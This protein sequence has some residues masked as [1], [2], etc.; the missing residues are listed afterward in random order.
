M[1]T[2]TNRLVLAGLL[3]GLCGCND[4]EIQTE[5]DKDEFR[6]GSA[7][8]LWVTYKKNPI[9]AGEATARWSSSKNGAIGEGTDITLSDLKAG[10]HDLVVEVTRDGK[11]AK[12]KRRIEITNDS[13]AATIQ[14]PLQGTKLGVG[15]PLALRGSAT[16]PEDG[17]LTG[18]S[19][20]WSS[21]LDGDLGAGPALELTHLRP[22]T[23][24]ISMVA[25]DRAGAESRARV[26][27][28][29]TNEAPEV[30]ISQPSG[31]VTI[32]VTDQLRLRGF[33]LDRDHRLG[34]ERVAGSSLE[35][36]SSKDGKLGVGEELTV[37][38]LSGGTHVVELL[39]KDEFGKVGRASLK[40]KVENQPPRVKIRRPYPNKFFSAS[41]AVRFEVEAED[42]EAALDP[43]DI[44][45]RSNKDGVIGRGYDFSSDRLSEGKHEVTCT[46]TD[47]H[48]ASA[49]DEVTLQINNEAPTA[50]IV[51]PS[52]GVT[53]R[54]GETL[55]VEGQGTDPEDGTLDDDRLEWSVVKLETGKSRRLGTGRRRTDSVSS[56]ANEVGFGRLELRLVATDRDGKASPVVALALTV[57]NRA[58]VVHLANPLSGATVAQ[59]VKLLCSGYGNDPD[60]GRLLEGAELQWSARRVSDGIMRELGKGTR[61][62]VADLLP[63][64]WEIT[65]TGIDPDDQALRH[66]AKVQVT[67][68]EAPAAPPT[69]SVTPDS[70]PAPVGPDT[71]GINTVVGQ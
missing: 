52:A 56:F 43:N 54:F 30:T 15:K 51:S 50:R 39:A 29:V 4:L 6:F 35:W 21:S 55:S 28:E 68:T 33:A 19:L 11:S 22:G 62:E 31:D 34:P 49:K 48:G 7:V 26:S 27:I 69:T 58:P 9:P 37:A 13:P 60:R 64:V 20:R 42:P 67:V 17:P 66:A 70:T 47:K 41:E 46:V 59:G 36:V 32:K 63:G 61:L 2:R 45:W 25:R 3:L 14:S 71:V 40:V 8:H 16:D 53:V 57:E 5:G 23:H 12:K 24:E 38:S 65:L 10:R 44:V 18:E 1:T